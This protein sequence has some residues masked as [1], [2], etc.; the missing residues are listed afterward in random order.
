MDMTKKIFLSLLILATTSPLAAQLA[1]NGYYRVQNE[2]TKRYI[3]IIDNRGSIDVAS[4]SADLG[5]LKTIRPYDEVVCDPSTIVYIE[6]KNSNEYNLAGQGTD[7]YKIIGHYLKI[8][9]VGNFYRA[10]QEKG[11][12][13]T[14]LNDI[15]TDSDY[16]K[17][18]TNDSRTRDWNITPVTKDGC[19][20]G[21]QPDVQAAG[22]YYASFFAGFPFNTCSQD[23][24]VYYIDRVV[25]DQAVYKELTGVVPASTPVIVACVS[26]K[27]SDNKLD[28]VMSAA[29]APA[30]NLLR[31]VY[32][33]ND[34]PV[35]YNRVAY[36]PATMRVLGILSDGSLGF[37]TANI[38]FIPA[39]QMYLS[40]P[41]GTPAELKLVDADHVNAIGSV[42]ADAAS[43]DVY[44]LDGHMVRQQATGL[45]GLAKGIYIWK[46]RK[47]IVR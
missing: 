11:A 7:A 38:D 5:A 33:D 8:N 9:K 19:Y 26:D 32:F 41:A 27:P 44:S 22:K 20:F 6:K 3:S 17:V 21:V 18:L 13:R 12:T 23:M 24:K 15:K 37:V 40:V 39:N 1:G 25:K 35:H 43:S 47:H 2:V 36:V 14:Y 34:N 31:G 28:I 42:Q 16:G 4:T 45:D 10:Y 30:D 29:K 46:G